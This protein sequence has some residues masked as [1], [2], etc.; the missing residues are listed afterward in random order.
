[1]SRGQAERL[2]PLLE[3]VLFDQDK[4]WKDVDLLAVGIGPGNFTGIRISVS[5]ARGLALGL[6]IPVMGVSMFEVMRH[7]IGQAA[8]PA[9]IVSLEGPRNTAYV[10]HFRYGK[11]QSNPIQ[12]D[13]AAPPKELQL[14]L[15]MRVT[16]FKA[17]LIAMPFNA[18]SNVCELKNIPSRIANCADQRW[19]SGETQPDRPAPLY[20]RSADAAP[21]RDPTPTILP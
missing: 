11:P 13:P 21:P 4:S 9:Q 19:N 15:N 12:I 7:T 3:S 14:P 6:G 8:E 2:M 17:D 5:A 18:D 10:Q 16:G 20:I 1:M